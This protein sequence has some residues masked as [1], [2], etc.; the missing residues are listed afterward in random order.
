MMESVNALDSA[1]QTFHYQ[2]GGAAES[3]G[4]GLIACHASKCLSGY[5]TYSVIVNRTNTSAEF[6]QFLI[7]GKVDLTITEATIGVA[8]WQKAI[9]HGFFIIF[10]LAIGGEYPDVMCDCSTPTDGTTSGETM[11]VAYVAVYEKGGNFTPAGK[12]TATGRITGLKGLCLDNQNSRNVETNPIFLHACRNGIGGEQWSVYSDATLRVQG[13]CLDDVAG[14]TTSGSWVD[15]FPCTGTAQQVWTRKS[16]GEIVNPRTGLC[17]ADP[18]A[19][20]SSRIVIE[21]CTGAAEQRW[22]YPE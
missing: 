16:N 14:G 8:A 21:N 13:G 19:N 7:D 18:L 20:T 1:S 2:V 15:W 3:T 10:D 22:T 17:L 6:V 4:T 11:S 5:H 9:D 12:A